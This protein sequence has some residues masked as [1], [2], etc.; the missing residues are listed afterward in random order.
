MSNHGSYHMDIAIAALSRTV[1]TVGLLAFMAWGFAGC[2]AEKDRSR[3]VDLSVKGAYSVPP[4]AADQT[5]NQL[6]HG[7]I[8]EKSDPTPTKPQ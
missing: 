6:P 7:G 4:G 8:D 3:A 2:T 5:R 1:I